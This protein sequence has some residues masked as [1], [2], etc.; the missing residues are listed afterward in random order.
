MRSTK[1]SN[2]KQTY[3][4]PGLK[5]EA[6][7]FHFTRWCTADDETEG[8]KLI[9]LHKTIYFC[10]SYISLQIPPLLLVIYKITE[11]ESIIF[12]SRNPLSTNFI[13][14]LRRSKKNHWTRILLAYRLLSF[15][16][17]LR[18]SQH[19]RRHLRPIVLIFLQAKKNVYIR[20]EAYLKEEKSLRKSQGV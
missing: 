14:I 17:P 10:Q 15:H 1:S 9:K 18:P 4:W 13:R 5:D 8:T 6:R 12:L 16:V 2:Y 20:D 11:L 19:H 7:A 3:L